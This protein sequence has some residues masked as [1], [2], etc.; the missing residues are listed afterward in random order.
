M[1]TLSTLILLWLLGV[2]PARAHSLTIS[3][4]ELR[5][6]SANEFVSSWSQLEGV[7]DPSAAYLVLRPLFPEHCR[8]EPPRLRCPGQGLT[9]RLGFAGLGE[10]SSS[11]VLHVQL[12]DAPSETYT[13]SAS[14]PQLIRKASSTEGGPLQR[15]FAYLTIGVEHIW[16]GWDHLLFVLGL[17][18]LVRSRA[19]LIWTIS[20]FTLAH[21][22]TLSAATLG[23]AA[24]PVPP[25]EAVIAL[26]IACLAVELVKRQRDGRSGL[27]TR[28]PWLV[29]FAFGLLHGL[30][31]ASALAEL[32]LTRA[33]LPLALLF[34][35]LGVELGQ[36]VF[37]LLVWALR[38]WLRKLST[39]FTAVAEPL[40]H[41][42]MG[43]LAMYWLLERVLSFAEPG[44]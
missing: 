36:L 26:S 15:A 1:K 2:L 21:S 37:V 24:L 11:A 28:A 40:G 14:Q 19:S 12:L 43:S 25:V 33:E 17:L 7:H 34:F 32:T 30:G 22:L 38:P 42:A 13:F 18:Y 9:G 20:A 35:N 39:R 31:F 44:P 8:F 41:Y 23:W 6:L 27:A 3:V 29:A 16:L 5:Q 10:L 4:L